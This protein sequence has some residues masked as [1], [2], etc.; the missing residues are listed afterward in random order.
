MIYHNASLRAPQTR[1]GRF[2]V[3]SH[4]NPRL[5][6]ENRSESHTVIFSPMHN[7]APDDW[8]EPSG[9]NS[10]RKSQKDAPNPAENGERVRNLLCER[11]ALD[12]AARQF[13][14]FSGF[15]SVVS[16]FSRSATF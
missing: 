5:L 4:K 6:T 16:S 13:F 10:G 2:Y 14:F 7:H 8:R 1:S 11:E 15:C 12:R 9:L 3:L